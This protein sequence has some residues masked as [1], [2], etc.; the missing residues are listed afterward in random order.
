MI[1]INYIDE[2]K[3]LCTKEALITTLLGYVDTSFNF[4]TC[5]YDGYHYNIFRDVSTGDWYIQVS[6][7]GVSC[8][9]VY[10]GWYLDSKD[11]PISEAI[12]EAVRV[13]GILD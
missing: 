4:L 2:R 8:G 9:S 10:D 12:T 6:I 7:V 13:S 1:E 3:K 5:D 11:K